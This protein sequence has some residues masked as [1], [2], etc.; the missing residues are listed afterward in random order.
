[1]KIVAVRILLVQVLESEQ[2]AIVLVSMICPKPQNLKSRK[3]LGQ[4]LPF[5]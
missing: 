5:A 4:T 2:K 3:E 1:L